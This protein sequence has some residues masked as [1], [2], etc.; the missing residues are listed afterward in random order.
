MAATLHDFAFSP[1]IEDSSSGKRSAP[2]PCVVSFFDR[3]DLDGNLITFLSEERTLVDSIKMA[4]IAQRD[5][6]GAFDQLAL[7][8]ELAVLDG[9][10]EDSYTASRRLVAIAPTTQD[11]QVYL[12]QA[13]MATRRYQ[14][15]LRVLHRMDLTKGWL[16]DLSQL[17]QWDLNAHRLTGDIAGGLVEWRRLRSRAPDDYVTCNAGILLFASHGR[18][19]DVEAL[20]ERCA[21]LPGAPA[22]TS[23]A[24]AYA[25][26]AYRAQGHGDASVRAISRTVSS[27]NESPVTDAG[28]QRALGVLHSTLGD[29]TTAY[30]Y[31]RADA[32]SATLD[33]RIALAVAAAHV[34]DT[35]TV[36]ATLRWLD[37]WQQRAPRHG[38]DKMF[39]AFIL[40]AGGNRDGALAL[41]SKSLDEGVAPAWNR[42]YLRYELQPLRGDERFERLIRPR[43]S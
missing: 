20:I 37:G 31:L 5:R 22:N 36:D 6:L 33:G 19:H 7:D 12:A 24:Y 42:W 17:R 21:K 29:W 35:A 4:A 34:R 38:A 2:E 3:A 14:E 43:P 10:L 16:K 27:W 1:Y 15:A 39:R 32:D 41:L 25:G 28:R 11:A 13:A 26:G 40:L 8:R 9:R 18:E 30:R 23:L